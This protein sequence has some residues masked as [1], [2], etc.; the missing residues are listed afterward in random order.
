MKLTGIGGV[1]AAIGLLLAAGAATAAETPAIHL[2]TAV[3]IGQGI[4]R[5][6]VVES[7]TG[8]PASIA[9]VLSEKALEGLPAGHAGSHE[10]HVTELPMPAK[11]PKTGYDHATID[12]NPNGHVPEGI[13]SAAHF[14]VH[15]YLIDRASR[16]AITFKGEAAAEAAKEPPVDLVPAGFVVP[17]DGAV[18]KMGLHGVD[19]SGPEFK[20]KPFTATFIYGYHRGETVFMEPMVTKAFL[21]TKP[22]VTLAVRTPKAYSRP[23]WYPTRY[24]VAYDAGAKTYVVAMTGLR[25]WR[26]GEAPMAA[27]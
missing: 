1:A 4:A 8:Q 13:Y 21:E 3:K 18:E 9:V 15:F 20:G 16:D 7:K 2:G 11:G 12:W 24:R 17:P 6:M 27:R 14:D 22:D 5:T 23:G 19:P 25:A 26:M 10:A